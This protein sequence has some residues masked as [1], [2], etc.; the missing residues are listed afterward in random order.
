MDRRNA[1]STQGQR[2]FSEACAARARWRAPPS[3][4]AKLTRLCTGT[5]DFSARRFDDTTG[6]AAFVDAGLSALPPHVAAAGEAVK[7]LNLSENALT[8]W[9]GFEALTGL[10]TLILDK[11]GLEGLDGAPS[12]PALK[13][14]W[15]NN[16]QVH[17]LAAFMDSVTSNFPGL[18]T[19][20]L[21][22]NPASP[23][24]VALSQEDI[25]RAK[26]YRLYIIYRMPALAFLDATP[27]STAEREE[28]AAK[29]KFLAVRKSAAAAARR[30]SGVAGQAG[31]GSRR[32]SAGMDGGLSSSGG[33][34]H[35]K[36]EEG[37][38]ATASPVAAS[39]VAAEAAPA[40]RKPSAFLAYSR[41]SYDG[42][43][44]EG[45]RFITTDQ[46]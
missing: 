25:A 15:F 31:T 42:K 24:M 41:S 26:R 10:T 9:E 38:S 36:G 12:L 32:A 7:T 6:D 8:S 33:H 14:L 13:E 1:G 39:A 35:A 23:P 45:N 5:S 2:G 11:N 19:L 34:A 21:M 43:H 44:S 29:G 40:T 27:V 3:S 17:D 18:T 46:L 22:R 16:N 37:G 20:S 28:A 30:T 4:A